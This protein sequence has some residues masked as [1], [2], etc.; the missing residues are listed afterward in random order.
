MVTEFNREQ[1]LELL[2][3]FNLLTGI[4]ICLFDIDFNEVLAYPEAQ[5]EYCLNI[6]GCA[7]GIKKCRD[8]DITALSVARKT[9]GFHIYSCHA[10]FI[11]AVCPIRYEGDTLGYLMFGHVREG[12]SPG[13]VK[14]A[15]KIME[16]CAG[17]IYL[18]R[19]IKLKENA[20]EKRLGEYLAANLSGDLSVDTLCTCF[21]LS[22]VSLYSLFNRMYG[23]SPAAHI[24]TLRLE[25]ACRLLKTTDKKIA[26]IASDSGFEDYNY[27][28]KQFKKEYGISP[29]KYRNVVGNA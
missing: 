8:C 9:K 2:R 24:R 21:N 22:R 4:R 29:G 25:R 26:F 11:E 28:A 14:A 1:I 17:Y 20:L 23:R 27:F 7:E 6:R 13:Q 15:A 10:G 5:P 16:S 19:L 12:T 18:S 3:D